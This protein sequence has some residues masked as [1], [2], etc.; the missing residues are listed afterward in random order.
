MVDKDQFRSAMA[1][2]ASGV[3]VVTVSDGAG[4]VGGLTANAFSSLSLDPPLIL[5]CVDKLSKAREYL[6][7]EKAFTLHFLADDQETVAMAFAQRGPDKANGID[8]HTNQRGVPALDDYL[9]AV[10]CDLENTMDGGDHVIIVGR[11]VDIKNSSTDR[12][13]LTYY[14]G[15]INTLV[16]RDLP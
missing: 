11:V 13:P 16:P 9:V 7:L 12:A 1:H 8:W 4:G 14:K 3:T 10:E 5:I 6:D 15:K 2:F